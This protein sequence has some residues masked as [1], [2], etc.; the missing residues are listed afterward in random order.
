MNQNI[1]NR[2]LRFLMIGALFNGHVSAIRCRC[3]EAELIGI[4]SSV[5]TVGG[6]S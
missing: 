2:R 6:V 4:N 3:P 5:P 1:A